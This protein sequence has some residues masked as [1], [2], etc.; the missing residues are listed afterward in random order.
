MNKAKTESKQD[1]L[2]MIDAEEALQI[3]K[4]LC[5]ED[6]DLAKRIEDIF[7]QRAKEV[8]VESIAGEILSDLE[9]LDVENLWDRS[10][11]SRHGYVEPIDEAY[12]MITEVLKP[13][14]DNMKRYHAMGMF[15]EEMIY[16]M[17]IISGLKEFDEVSDTEFK[18]WASDVSTSEIDDILND[19]KKSCKDPKLKKAMDKFIAKGE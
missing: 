8:D 15:H 2:N 17:G 4:I 1:V 16:C 9:F 7:I 13:H 12:I 3:L 10:G 11:S 5:K 18:D 6:E 14:I 19:W